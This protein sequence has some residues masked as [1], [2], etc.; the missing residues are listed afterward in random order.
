MHL[1]TFSHA[2][3]AHGD[4]KKELP[5][6]AQQSPD[7]M[8]NGAETCPAWQASG[9]QGKMYVSLPADKQTGAKQG[10]VSRATTEREAAQ[11]RERG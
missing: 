8:V 1:K 5:Q 2:R 11:V 7:G 6:P 10:G 9:L 4:K 3:H